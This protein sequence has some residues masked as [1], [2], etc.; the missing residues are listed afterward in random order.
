MDLFCPICTTKIDTSFPIKGISF[1]CEQSDHRYRVYL[2]NKEV[3]SEIISIIKN[4]IESKVRAHRKPTYVQFYR[5][6]QVGYDTVVII[7]ESL[8]VEE[9]IKNIIRIEKTMILA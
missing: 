4:G 7:E 5:H 6:G 8:T 9:V 3:E 1:D 2:A